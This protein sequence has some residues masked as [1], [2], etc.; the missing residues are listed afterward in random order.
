M[1]R[2]RRSDS[3][4]GP[5]RVRNALQGPPNRSLWARSKKLLTH[6]STFVNSSTSTERLTLWMALVLS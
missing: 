3:L 6:R 4:R 5:A 1:P 2:T